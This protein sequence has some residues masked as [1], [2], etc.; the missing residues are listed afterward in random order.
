MPEL[1]PSSSSRPARRWALTLV[2]VVAIA[3]IGLF[4]R[5]RTGRSGAAA[6][7]SA[8]A[9]RVVPVPVAVVETRDL[10]I[11]LEGIGTVAAYNS[12]I[13]KPQVDGRIDKILFVEGQ[14]VKQ[15][16]V[17]VQIDP[18]PFAIQLQQAN[19][20]LLRDK[21]T[22]ANAR[23][24]LARN[25]KLF[26]T[27]VGSQQAIDDSKAEVAK[28][29]AIVAGDA[30]TIG[31]AQLQLDFA[32]I[33]SPIDGVT[34]VRQVDL[35]NIVHPSDQN[36]IVLITQI[37]PITVLFTL[38]EDELP[39]INAAMAEQKLVV[40]AWGR[41][42]KQRL[43]TGDLLLV[44]NKID[45]ATATI[46]LKAVFPNKDRVLWPSQFVK[47]KL[48]LSVKKG[49][50]VVASTVVQRGPQGAFAYVVKPGDKVELAPVE[51]ELTQGEWAVIAKG[52]APGDR[53]VVDGQ[54]QLRPGAKIVARP[55]T[56]A[57][58]G[59][60]KAAP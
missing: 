57:W 45:P 42:G 54:N 50:V 35:G 41:D 51:V 30:A 60:Q 52:L 38:P 39:R 43:A 36:G 18:R 29:E 28:D 9:E 53:V 10:P 59:G 44:D 17:L 24:A 20:A 16:D 11:V 21:A 22:L 25:V 19:A 4:V 40:E 34:G 33:K 23:V 31:S 6:T 46:R 1:E 12:V 7:P 15:G 49:A 2:G 47:A 26:E 55:V 27:G 32:R 13:V 14:S 58:G 5:A 3:A 56:S 8:A 48:N 37:D